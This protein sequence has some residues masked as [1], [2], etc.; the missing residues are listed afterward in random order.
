MPEHVVGVEAARGA[1]KEPIFTTLTMDDDVGGQLPRVEGWSSLRHACHL[2]D[3]H[4]R[5]IGQTKPPASAVLLH[6]ITQRGATFAMRD[7]IR[8]KIAGM[9]PRLGQAHSS[10]VV[11][12]P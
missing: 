7:P 10:V 3:Q 2:F 8:D 11:A 12:R 6:R 4:R 5:V 1:A 9:L